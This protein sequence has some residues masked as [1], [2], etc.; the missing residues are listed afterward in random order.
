M[1]WQVKFLTRGSWA[2]TLVTRAGTDRAI[3]PA[4]QQS[5]QIGLTHFGQPPHILRHLVIVQISP[6]YSPQPLSYHR[7]RFMPPPHQ[8]FLNAYRRCAHSLLVRQPHDLEAAIT[9]PCT[10]TVRAPSE[11][12]YF[13]GLRMPRFR[14]CCTVNCPKQI[15]RVLSGCSC[16][17]KW[18]IRS[19]NARRSRRASFSYRNPQHAVVGTANDNHVASGMSLTPSLR[20][21]I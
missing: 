13:S 11:V 10:A 9:A 5:L 1:E 21:K 6:G 14:H 8:R 17:L 7:D 4:P 12:E 16:N 3:S 2:S 19:C 20:P 18:A 15:N